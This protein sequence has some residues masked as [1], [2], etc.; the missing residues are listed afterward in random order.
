M[1]QFAS[2]C[3]KIK[4]NHGTWNIL[5]LKIV[6]FYFRKNNKKCKK[7]VHDISTMSIDILDV[8]LHPSELLQ[9]SIQP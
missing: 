3:I 4:K 8:K 6:V 2:G 1:H 7:T 9:T 5:H